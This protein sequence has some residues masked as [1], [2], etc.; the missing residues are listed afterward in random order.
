MEVEKYTHHPEYNQEFNE[1]VHKGIACRALIMD[2]EEG[3]VPEEHNVI[4][5]HL[6]EMLEMYIDRQKDVY[7]KVTGFDYDTQKKI[8][9]WLK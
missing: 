8:E 6:K 3:N 4:L 5:P 9:Q 2:I 1:L 7:H